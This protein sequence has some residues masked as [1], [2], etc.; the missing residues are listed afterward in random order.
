MTIVELFL[1]ETWTIRA[2]GDTALATLA[3]VFLRF[4]QD[5]EHVDYEKSSDGH[6]SVLTDQV[7]ISG[8]H[9][10]GK[11]AMWSTFESWT[12]MTAQ[13]ELAAAEGEQGE[14]SA[15]QPP[16]EEAAAATDL[17]GSL[18]GGFSAV[19]EGVQTQI[20]YQ[21]KALD[22]TMVMHCATSPP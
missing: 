3:V 11:R 7:A 12:G 8:R 10:P 18:W 16:A 9:Q 13:A 4:R 17:L 22:E 14:A 15:E 20:E 1:T 6:F 21:Q 19:A 2:R 5:R